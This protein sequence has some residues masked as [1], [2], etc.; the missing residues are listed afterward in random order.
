MEMET[1]IRALAG[2]SLFP[3]ASHGGWKWLAQ[4]TVLWA[5]R[6]CLGSGRTLIPS[7]V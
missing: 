4:E 6:P 5:R 3:T 7:C 2:V 1:G